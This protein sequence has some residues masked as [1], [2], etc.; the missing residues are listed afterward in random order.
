MP[1][2][3]TERGQILV[4]IAAAFPVKG[5]VLLHFGVKDTGIG[6]PPRHRKN[7]LRRSHR[8]TA[9]WH[10]S[11][12]GRAWLGHLR[13]SCGD[14]GGSDLGGKHPTKG[15]CLSLH[16]GP[17][18]GRGGSRLAAE[19]RMEG[20]DTL[21]PSAGTLSASLAASTAA[22]FESCWRKI[23]AL[24]RAGPSACSKSAVSQSPSRWMAAGGCPNAGRGVRSG[25]DGHSN[26]GD[27]RL[28]SNGGIRKGEK[29]TGRR[30]PIIALTAHALKEDRERCLSAA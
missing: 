18:T 12:E 6:I 3:F 17:G 4:A 7:Y 26:A 14:D 16:F 22:V 24:S 20:L 13:S 2:S 1:S 21:P 27:G 25:A 9:P 8:P 19:V 23:T 29:V 15:K 5:R 10:A 11:M 28:R 30:T